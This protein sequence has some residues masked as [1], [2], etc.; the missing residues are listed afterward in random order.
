MDAGSGQG[1]LPPFDSISARPPVPQKNQAPVSRGPILY[2]ARRTS[3]LPPSWFHIVMA[4]GLSNR[5]HRR[6]RIAS[7]LSQ[8]RW[9]A[10]RGT[11]HLPNSI[12]DGPSNCCERGSGCNDRS[13]PRG[14]AARPP[15]SRPHCLGLHIRPLGICRR[16]ADRGPSVLVNR[17]CPCA[18]RCNTA[19][20][21]RCP[22]AVILLIRRVQAML[23]VRTET[24]QLQEELSPQKTECPRH[25]HVS[26]QR[27]GSQ[28]GLQAGA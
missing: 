28:R 8:V 19:S 13:I 26:N 18:P 22:R 17:V 7:E 1:R 21:A 20:A 27:T 24:A 14:D 5:R 23:P 6:H 9:F 3:D 16:F 12:K 11:M 15:Y 25:R 2:G 10:G 4:I